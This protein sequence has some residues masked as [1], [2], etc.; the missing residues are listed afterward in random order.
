MANLGDKGK[1]R[2]KWRVCQKFIK[3]LVKYSNE[4]TKVACCMLTVFDFYKNDK[5]GENLARGNEWLAK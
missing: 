3:G 4:M 2:Q 1:F 5:C